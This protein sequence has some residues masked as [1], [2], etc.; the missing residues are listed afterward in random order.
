VRVF[1]PAEP[2][3]LTALRRITD[4]ADLRPLLGQG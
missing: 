4:P 3:G 1:A 2:A